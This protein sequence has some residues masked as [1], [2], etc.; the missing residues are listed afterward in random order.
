MCF[1]LQMCSSVKVKWL[2]QLHNT[3]AS[4]DGSVLVDR[5]KVEALFEKLVNMEELIIM[6]QQLLHLK[7]SQ[8]L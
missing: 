7:V 3:W 6:P 2:E 4:Q 8:C 1:S 5:A